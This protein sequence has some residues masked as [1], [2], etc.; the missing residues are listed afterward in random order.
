LLDT[1]RFEHDNRIVISTS[2][3]SQHLTTMPT[4]TSRSPSPIAAPPLAAAPGPRATALN[5]AFN[6]ALS[7]TL[8]KVTYDNFAACFPTPA[9]YR[10]ETMDAFW[11]DFTGRLEGVCKG[12]FE[13]L[14]EE[15]NVVAGLNEL[16]QLVK[17]AEKRRDAAQAQGEGQ[18]VEP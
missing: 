17:D 16:D 18:V 8:K 14:L 13:A 1:T 15:R 11:R 7:A 2:L 9:K 6:L 12:Q 4:A 3:A 5:N 10:P